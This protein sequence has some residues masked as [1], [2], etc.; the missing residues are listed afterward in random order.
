MLP[1]DTKADFDITIQHSFAG[2]NQPGTKFFGNY[3]RAAGEIQL[4][5]VNDEF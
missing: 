2:F 1:S 5:P 3:W 4:G